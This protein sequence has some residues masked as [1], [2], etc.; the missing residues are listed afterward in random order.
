MHEEVL[1]PFHPDW[2]LLKL[3]LVPFEKGHNLPVINFVYV[4]GMPVIV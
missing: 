1:A 3:W 4:V 2:S